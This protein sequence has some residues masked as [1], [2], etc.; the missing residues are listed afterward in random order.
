[1]KLSGNSIDN[2]RMFSYCWVVFTQPFLLLTPP[3]QQVGW[4]CKESG[5][6]WDSWS[7]P[8][9][10]IFQ[11]TGHHGQ[12]IKL[13]KKVMASIFSSNHYTWGSPALLEMAKPAGPWQVVNEFIALPAWLLLYLLNW[14]HLKP[15]VFALW[16]FQLSH[17]SH[18]RR[19]S[20]WLCR[21]QLLA[22]VTLP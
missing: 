18:C 21:L 12:H 14:F 15:Q 3:Q 6:R 19:V 9:K 11:T 13:G 22:R 5:H 20:K 4:R 1:M 17:P 16:P 10:G 2:S 8:A 7:Q